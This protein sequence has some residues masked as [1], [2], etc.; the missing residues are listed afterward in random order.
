MN[1]PVKTDAIGQTRQWLEQVVIAQQL[2]PFAQHPYQSGQVRMLVCDSQRTDELLQ[3]L[4]EELQHLNSVP[5]TETE[6]TLLIHPYV[7]T[8]FQRY[9]DFLDLVDEL[10]YQEGYEGIFQVASFHPDYLFMGTGFNDAEN[11][12][13]RSPHPMLHILREASLEKAI[14][15]HPDI[16]AIPERNIAL[17]N[18]KGAEYWQ[19]L[20]QSLSSSRS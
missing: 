4:L 10:I 20:L 16:D 9:N 12:T 6:T 1:N 14:D 2:C 7:L 5:A 3:T 8:D 18:D 15:Q 17:M 11:Y 13:N 19:Q